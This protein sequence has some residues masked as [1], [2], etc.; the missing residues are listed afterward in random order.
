M[1]DYVMTY[2]SALTKDNMTYVR[3]AILFGTMEQNGSETYVFVN[4]AMAAQNI[5]LDLDE[6]VFDDAV[7]K[8]IYET[9]EQ[10]FHEAQVIG[11][12]LCRTG[13]SVR[14][15]DKIKKTHFENFPGDGKILY[16]RDPLDEEEAMYVYH[17]QD[18]IRQNGY[19]IYYVKNKEMQEYLVKQREEQEAA[20]SYERMMEQRRD[21]R[22]VSQSRK[23]TKKKN[24]RPAHF[25]KKTV[26]AATLMFC[27]GAAGT[28][29]LFGQD[30]LPE[31]AVTVLSNTV[32]YFR[33]ESSSKNF[34]TTAVFTESA[35]EETTSENKE[36]TEETISNENIYTVQKGDTITKISRRLFQT[37]KY[38]D[39][40][41]E[42]N[43]LSE[44]D[45]IYPGQKLKIPSV[46]L[47]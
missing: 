38:V 7:W 17:G 41:L 21:R 31:D 28:Y 14:L 34:S 32:N 13:M 24:K 35:T 47:Q 40:I 25:I 27:L 42:E 2:L 11:W 44:S 3:G 30:G 29:A 5:E 1:E 20:V 4:G 18:L 6:T 10:Y 26:S 46:K 23:K 37:K 36:S 8:K 16:V 39:A 43:G 45:S 12:Y 15:N 22:L 19:Y 9:K 33:P